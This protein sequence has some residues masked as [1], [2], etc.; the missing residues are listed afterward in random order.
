[1]LPLKESAGDLFKKLQEDPRFEHVGIDSRHIKLPTTAVTGRFM[2]LVMETDDEAALEFLMYSVMMLHKIG[3]NGIL[4]RIKHAYDI[5]IRGVVGDMPEH[6][7]LGEMSVAFSHFD[8]SIEVDL[9]GD[10][11]SLRVSAFPQR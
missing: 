7:S 3:D 2:N 9:F 11:P 10:K 1:M 6:P 8:N 5:E 4:V